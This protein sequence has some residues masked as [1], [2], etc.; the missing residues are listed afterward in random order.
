ML[1]SALQRYARQDCMLA[2]S[3]EPFNAAAE[4]GRSKAKGIRQPHHANR[5]LK[6]SWNQILSCSPHH[7]TPVDNRPLY[8]KNP[9]TAAIAA[10]KPISG[11]NLVP[12]PGVAEGLA[13]A[14][15][16]VED[17][18]AVLDAAAEEVEAGACFTVLASSVPHA[19]SLHLS[20]PG[21]A[22]LQRA[23]VSWHASSGTVP[24]Y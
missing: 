10:T 2:R 6:I 14:A 3:Q 17:G 12:A 8:S 11:R 4:K 7:T 9:I 23:K 19:G 21:Y 5:P 18:A 24:R 16:P 22:L 15:A 13:A 20:A 1:I